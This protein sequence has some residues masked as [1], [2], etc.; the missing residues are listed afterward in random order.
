MEPE[1]FAR[2][3]GIRLGDLPSF[4]FRPI[5]GPPPGELDDVLFC[6]ERSR[7]F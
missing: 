1:Y 6:A 3:V 5:H 7:M 4:R 2:V